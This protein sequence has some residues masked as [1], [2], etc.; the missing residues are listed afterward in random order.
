[1]EDLTG[2][3]FGKLVAMRPGSKTKSGRTTWVCRCDCGKEKEILAYSLKC[4]DTR[5]C[6]CEHYPCRP[7]HSLV[8]SR[9]GKLVVLEYLPGSKYKCLCD[10]GN[11]VE[12]KTDKL[13]HGLTRS[14]GCLRRE[15]AAKRAT[16]HGGSK[17]ALYAV[18]RGMHQRCENPKDKNYKWYG[19]RGIQ[20][21]SEW[22]A[23]NYQ[24]FKDWALSTGYQPGLTIDRIDMNGNYEPGNCR[25]ITIQE[26]QRNRRPPT[27]NK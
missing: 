18:L 13:S 15:T 7:L 4:G 6:G 11:V 20:V 17:D 21:C 19:Q 16:K 8:G 5:S 1:M 24:V 27:R 10:C 23:A 3:R 26:Q 9:V 2:R 25:W 14:C 12:V 22:S